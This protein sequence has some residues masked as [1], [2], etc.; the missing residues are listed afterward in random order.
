MSIWI[1]EGYESRRDYLECLADDYG[2]DVEAVF[3]LASLLGSIE[4][5][6]GLVTAVED[7]ADSLEEV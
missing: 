6:D 1:D 7:L 4:D 5:F 3:A 2:V